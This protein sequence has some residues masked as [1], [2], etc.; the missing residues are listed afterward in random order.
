MFTLESVMELQDLVKEVLEMSPI[1]VLSNEGYEDH[2]VI[3][4][5]D[6]GRKIGT[7]GERHVKLVVGYDQKI[8]PKKEGKYHI[9]NFTP[10][11]YSK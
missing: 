2:S 5:Y 7:R 3:L 10:V 11:Q 9:W 6:V 8:P 1:R 4:I